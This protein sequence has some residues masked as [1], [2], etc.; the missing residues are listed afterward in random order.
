LGRTPIPVGSAIKAL[1]RCSS[2]GRGRLSGSAPSCPLGRP[3]PLQLA[4]RD[5]RGDHRQF[6]SL[7]TPSASG[8]LPLSSWPLTARRRQMTNRAWTPRRSWPRCCS[9]IGTMPRRF[10]RPPRPPGDGTRTTNHR[11]A[12]H[13]STPSRTIRG[14]VHPNSEFLRRVRSSQGL[15]R[16]SKGIVRTYDT[17][18]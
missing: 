18:S 1:A 5:P 17:R 14:L 6:P 11:A 15:V 8:G 2:T 16:S 7:A 12:R 4:Q 13:R 10:A 9:L 3:H